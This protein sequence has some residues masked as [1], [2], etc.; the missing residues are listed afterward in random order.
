MRVTDAESTD[1]ICLLVLW[2]GHACPGPVPVI[3]LA[4]IPSRRTVVRYKGGWWAISLLDRAEAELRMLRRNLRI[5]TRVI[6]D[7][8][9]PVYISV[10][11]TD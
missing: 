3:I 5:Y 10:C 8:A 6:A 7:N 2:V 4:I 11:L 9:S 1:F